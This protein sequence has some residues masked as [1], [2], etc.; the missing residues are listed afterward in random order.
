LVR[1][2]GSR[3]ESAEQIRLSNSINLRELRGNIGEMVRGADH[4]PSRCVTV[5]GRV[6]RTSV[7]ISIPPTETGAVVLRTRDEFPAQVVELVKAVPLGV[8]PLQDQPVPVRCVPQM[9]VG[10]HDDRVQL[11]ELGVRSSE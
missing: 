10:P 9:N 4:T 8:A 6:A 3:R 11:S 1:R 5:A 2:V 7:D